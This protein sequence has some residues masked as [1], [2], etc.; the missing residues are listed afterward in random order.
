MANRV[1][2]IV[3]ALVALPSFG[4]TSPPH[5]AVTA[6]AAN[7]PPRITTT[8]NNIALLN[9]PWSYRAVADD[10][11]GDALTWSLVTAPTGMT[12]DGQGELTYASA[13]EGGSH[14]VLRVE[15]PTGAYDEQSFLISTPGPTD[16][17]S[18]PTVVITSPRDGATVSGELDVIGTATDFA[19]TSY[20]VEL[21]RPG[22]RDDCIPIA[23]SRV[24][25]I[26]GLLAT[27]TIAGIDPGEWELWVVARDASGRSGRRSVA[28]TVANGVPP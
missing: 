25:V 9:T 19:F 2:F 3:S 1:S 23:H 24:P 5:G 14:I 13:A 26:T 18:A 11:D 4:C 10:A 6:T 28:V 22:T 16:A 15:D 21:C 8:P 20:M 27:R 17:R 12:H 7:T